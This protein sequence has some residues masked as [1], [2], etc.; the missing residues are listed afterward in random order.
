[1][2]VRHSTPFEDL[3]AQP[4]RVA[5]IRRRRLQRHG[6]V[7]QDRRLRRRQTPGRREVGHASVIRGDETRLLRG[8]QRRRHSR[9]LFAE[10]PDQTVD[11]RP[12]S[13]GSFENFGELSTNCFVKRQRASGVAYTVKVARCNPSSINAEGRIRSTNERIRIPFRV[14][15]C[16]LRCRRIQQTVFGRSETPVSVSRSLQ[17]AHDVGR[18]ETVCDSMS[19]AMWGRGSAVLA[20]VA[21]GCP[22]TTTGAYACRVERRSAASA[23]RGQ[24][25]CSDAILAKRSLRLREVTGSDRSEPRATGHGDH[26]WR[27]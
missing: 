11:S 5:S 22:W 3:Q 13:G 10:R 9:E 23:I 7:D 20:A 2:S 12:E 8:G 17:A 1:M 24:R 21:F 19:C 4:H 25:L 14:R 16:A 6:P 26:P 18:V 27:R 15:K